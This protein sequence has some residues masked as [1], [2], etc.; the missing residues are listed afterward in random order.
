M[1]H[2]LFVTTICGLLVS[3]PG[4]AQDNKGYPVP[5]ACSTAHDRFNPPDPKNRPNF[6]DLHI[7]KA[8]PTKKDAEEIDEA[9]RKK[10]GFLSLKEP[11][12]AGIMH[13]GLVQY[14]L[15]KD[16]SFCY[17]RDLQIQLDRASVELKRLVATRKPDEKLAMVLDIDETS[18]SSYCELNREGFGYVGSVYNGYL[19]SLDA[20]VPIPGTVELF[21]EARAA[22]VDVF[23]ITGRA[24][25]QTETTARNL[26]I[27]GYD[28]WAGLTLRDD[29]E[30]NMDTTYYKSQARKKIVD[31]HYRIILNVGDQWSDLNGKPAAEVSVKLPNPFYFLP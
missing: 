7:Q 25:D 21:N 19:T 12:N 1:T 10:E 16:E 18:L 30:R 20:S 3:A 6:P 31:Q 27:A 17:W 11:E 2:K 29:H 8:P 13:Y 9:G 24:H 22:G 28:N 14:A 15:C 23:F 5:V 26:H 4:M